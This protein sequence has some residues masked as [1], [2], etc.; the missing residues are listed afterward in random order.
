MMTN[1]TISDAGKNS[2]LLGSWDTVGVGGGS[3]GA[4]AAIS[5]ARGGCAT[6]LID[7]SIRMGGT[8]TNA[9][10][11][12]MMKSFTGHRSNFFDLEDKLH[13]LGFATRDEIGTEMRW[14]TPEAMAEALETMYTQAGGE[15]LYDTVLS[16]CITENGRICTLIVTTVQGLCAVKGTNFVDASGDAV[17]TRAAGVPTV[18]GDDN[19]NNQMTSLRFEMGGI[20][21]ETYR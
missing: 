21:A 18:H 9:L 4:S 2:P 6:L 14:F 11:T 1:K 19:G 12:P 16:D 7:K 5:S 15:I 20:D 13:E 3:A 17:L 10:V 8:A